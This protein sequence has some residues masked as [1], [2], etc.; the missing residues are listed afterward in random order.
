MTCPYCG[1]KGVLP[2][3]LVTLCGQRYFEAVR[4]EP[5]GGLGYA[6]AYTQPIE[7]SPNWTF[8]RWRDLL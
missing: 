6:S 1:G 2:G 8:N 4:C 7:T 5:C 3:K